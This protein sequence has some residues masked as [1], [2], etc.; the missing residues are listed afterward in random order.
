MKRILFAITWLFIVL[1]QV[2]AQEGMWLLTQI[3]HLDLMKKGL[4]IPV[5]KVF[6]QDHE[7]IANAVVQMGGGTAS[8]VSGDGLLLTN[9][10]VAYTAIQRSSSAGQD[11]LTNGFLAVNRNEE[12]QAP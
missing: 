2:H 11:Y 3:G 1:F 5:E 8:F 9:H 10:H 4:Q 6:S 12:I 7:C